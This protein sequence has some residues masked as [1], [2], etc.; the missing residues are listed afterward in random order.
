M[1]V[2]TGTNVEGGKETVRLIE[3]AGG[4]ASFFR[5]DVSN[6]SEV[7]AMVEACLSRYGGLDFAFNNA[8]SGRTEDE[9][10][11]AHS[12]PAERYLGPHS[13]SQPHGCLSVPEA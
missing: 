1:L 11:F 3:D 4:E 10:L 2:T 6:E 5:C 8:V 13:R 12:R 9:S 7:E